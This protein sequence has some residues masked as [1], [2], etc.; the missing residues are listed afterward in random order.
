MNSNI[1]TKQQENYKLQLNTRNMYKLTP[2]SSYTGIFYN[3][4]EIT[5]LSSKLTENIN[6]S[7]EFINIKPD[8]DPRFGTSITFTIEKSFD[9]LEKCWIKMKLPS[10]FSRRILEGI[11]NEEIIYKNKDDRI[12]YLNGIGYYIFNNIQLY[13]DGNCVQEITPEML[14]IY[15]YINN[16]IERT[17]TTRS[18]LHGYFGSKDIYNHYETIYNDEYIIEIPFYFNYEQNNLPISCLKNKTVQIICNIKPLTNLLHEPFTNKEI[19]N[20]EPFEKSVIFNPI[21]G[22]NGNISGIQN[23]KREED[24][25]LD[26]FELLC[27]SVYLDVNMRETMIKSDIKQEFIFSQQFMETFKNLG[28]KRLINMKIEPNGVARYIYIFARL[29]NNEKRGDYINLTNEV[30]NISSN[31]NERQRQR[32]IKNVSLNINREN[33]FQGKRTELMEYQQVINSKVDYYQN[34][35]EPIIVIPLL[36]NKTK[37]SII[38]ERFDD[39]R[40]QFLVNNDVSEDINIYVICE[41]SNQ[42]RIN[43]QMGGLLFV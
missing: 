3:N 26:S 42:L 17:L 18:E 6:H 11:R 23:T 28:N 1:T 25:I 27:S 37:G 2:P 13:I 33:I 8:S 14:H 43:K 29:L 40:L 15:H 16:N 38:Y 41:N 22:Y 24:M 20:I 12:E 39:I 36:N 31:Y 9:I 30:I 19:C 35:L 21:N 32:I 10:I 5:F 7:R 34:I 4:P